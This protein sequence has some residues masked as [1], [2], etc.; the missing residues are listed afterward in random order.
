MQEKN[1]SKITSQISDHQQRTAPAPSEGPSSYAQL[2][3]VAA[4]LNLDFADIVIAW[5]TVVDLKAVKNPRFLLGP[6]G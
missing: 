2:V 4:D 3:L 6:F 5:T 1:A